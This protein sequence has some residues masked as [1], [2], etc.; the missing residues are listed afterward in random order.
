LTAAT[1]LVGY[2]GG[3]ELVDTFGYVT[4][5]I[6]LVVAFVSAMAA[7]KWMVAWLNDRG[8]ELFGWYRVAVGVLALVLL[9]V[10]AV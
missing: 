5:L 9:A 7:V 4:P 6:G 2:R 1:M 10:G 3:G 8:F